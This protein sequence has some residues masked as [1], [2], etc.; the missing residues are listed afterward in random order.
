MAENKTQNKKADAPK[1]GAYD[2]IPEMSVGG[3]LKEIFKARVEGYVRT[4]DAIGYFLQG[5]TGLGPAIGGDAVRMSTAS[6]AL[7]RDANR[8]R[9]GHIIKLVSGPKQ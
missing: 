7:A 6:A 3:H 8:R 1:S 2:D 5:A 4:A 9:M